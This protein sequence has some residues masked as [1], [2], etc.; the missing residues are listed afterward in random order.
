MAEAFVYCWSDR[1]TSKVYVGMHK[2]SVDDGY[3]CSSKYMMPEYK[4]R[5]NDFT[6]QIVATGTLNDC[7]ALEIALLKKIVL[8]KN[9]CYNKVAGKFIVM[10]DDARERSRQAMI[11]RKP[12]I[13]TLKKMREAHSG[14][15]NH[16]F[17]KAHSEKSK[18][19]IAAAKTGKVGPRLGMTVSKETKQKIAKKLTGR[20]G[21]K[22]TDESRA[23]LSAAHMGKKQAPLSAEARRKLSESVKISWI[24]RREVKE[25]AK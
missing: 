8:N 17:G 21:Y 24:K 14:E 18:A 20:I 9:T 4:A 23:K 11:G 3:I 16:F 15:K 2:G 25:G 6:R 12:S 1:Q 10:S 7:R 13:E 19:K 22:H 5:P